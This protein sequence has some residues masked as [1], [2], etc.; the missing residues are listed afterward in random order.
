MATL[1]RNLNVWRTADGQS[2]TSQAEAEEYE[3]TGQRSDVNNTDSFGQVYDELAPEVKAGRYDDAHQAYTDETVAAGDVLRKQ[4]EEDAIATRRRL[5]NMASGRLTGAAP[6]INGLKV[7]QSN[8]LTGRRTGGRIQVD[9][10][11]QEPPVGGHPIA[12]EAEERV[13]DDQT[14]RDEEK[15]S[16]TDL[17]EAGRYNSSQESEE[18][19]RAQREALD[20]QAELYNVLSQFD[21]DAY[22]QRASD[23]ALKNQLAI[24]RS[25]P[26]AAGGADA[27]YQAIE[28][29]PEIQA[30][31]QRLANAELLQKQQLAAAVTG[32]MGDL[33]TSTRGQDVGESQLQSEFG[34]RIADGISNMTGLDWQ[35]D[36]K[37]SATLAQVA[38]A[39]DQSGI[40]WAKMDLQAQMA[41][42][43]RILAEKGLAQQW[44]MFKSSQEISE[45]DVFGGLMSIV[46]TGVSAAFGIGAL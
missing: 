31:Q 1:D 9:R 14:K 38:L 35:L 21:P 22:A 13:E 40:E 46:G 23:L 4:A 29:G 45:K 7:S 11:Y 36:N 33:A 37:E 10:S 30:E 28:S 42:A 20:K 41:E 8:A 32:Q 25:V 15:Q 27:L 2:F 39:L 16:L 17:Y 6:T 26:G 5:D 12:N 44:K 19:R 18:S 24:A 3:R 34:M 43:E